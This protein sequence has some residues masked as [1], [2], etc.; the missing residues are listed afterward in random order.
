MHSARVEERLMLLFLQTLCPASIRSHPKYIPDRVKRF[1]G[2]A[3]PMDPWPSERIVD[4]VD[5]V[6]PIDEGV[7]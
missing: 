7:M 1:T 5:D 4:E 6:G 3:S 2:E